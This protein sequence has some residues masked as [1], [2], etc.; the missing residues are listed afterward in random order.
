MKRST[1]ASKDGIESILL[2]F[3]NQKF[4]KSDQLPA[5]SSDG[6]PPVGF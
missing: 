6:F 3:K 5:E 2:P 4:A 1:L